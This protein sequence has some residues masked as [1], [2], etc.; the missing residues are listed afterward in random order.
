MSTQT[1]DL[2]LFLDIAS[3]TEEGIDINVIRYFLCYWGLIWLNCSNIF[4]YIIFLQQICKKCCSIWSLTS[5]LAWRVR[6]TIQFSSGFIAYFP[7]LFMVRSFHFRDGYCLLF[8]FV[9]WRSSSRVHRG[10]NCSVLDFFRPKKVPGE[11]TMSSWLW[12]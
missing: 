7:D 12:N 4:F 9:F 8:P 11:I 1:G 5:C 2:F 6:W 3:R 10:S